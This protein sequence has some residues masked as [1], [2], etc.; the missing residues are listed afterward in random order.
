VRSA[1]MEGAGSE[2][3]ECRVD[4]HSLFRWWRL[5]DCLWQSLEYRSGWNGRYRSIEGAALG[6][7]PGSAS[8]SECFREWTL[9]SGPAMA[10]RSALESR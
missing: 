10:S 4:R 1:D 5:S 7:P 3:A 9:V 2:P 6:V 8:R